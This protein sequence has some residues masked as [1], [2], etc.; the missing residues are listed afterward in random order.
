LFSVL[1]HISHFT[2]SV[3][4]ESTFVDL[5]RTVHSLVLDQDTFRHAQIVCQPRWRYISLT[6]CDSGTIQKLPI[7]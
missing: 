4:H 1:L 3:Y 6:E 7:Y 2:H 5:S